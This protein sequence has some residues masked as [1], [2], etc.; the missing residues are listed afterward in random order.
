[1]TTHQFNKVLNKEAM[2]RSCQHILDSTGMI[3]GGMQD[4]LAIT[5]EVKD[6]RT[7]CE[8]YLAHYEEFCKLKHEKL[9]VDRH[10]LSNY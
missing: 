5:K 6:L 8:D 4:N 1:M 7:R 3:V 9:Y 2:A 10:E